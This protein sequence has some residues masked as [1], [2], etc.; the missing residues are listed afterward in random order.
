M[1]F[2]FY[3]YLR[4]IFIFS[5]LNDISINTE[6][7]IQAVRGGDQRAFSTLYDNYSASLYGVV[8]KIVKSDAI[9]EDVMQDAFVNIWKKFQ[10]FDPA[11]G[12]IF[13]WMLN[14]SRNKAIDS[15]RKSK[16]M[17]EVEIQDDISNVGL[18]DNR[19][20]QLN[21]S[22]IG[23]KTMMNKLPPEQRVILD[24]IYFQGYTQQEVSDELEV[25]LGT[26]KSRVRIAMRE[27]RK[28]FKTIFIFWM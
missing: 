23:V 22:T 25:P 15:L 21:E 24:Y 17:G 5:I 10:T 20:S 13:T 27:L 6:Q 19:N 9:A 7:L 3:N 18:K 16:R 1:V 26:V 4:P 28:V 14:I 12:S 8:C 2:S 11:K